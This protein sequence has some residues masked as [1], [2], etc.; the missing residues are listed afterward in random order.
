MSSAERV[1]LTA[2]SC[3]E[4]DNWIAKYPAEQRQSAVMAALRIA[5]E[6]NGGWLH[7]DL[8]QAVAD[9]LD[10]AVI[11]V[12]EVATFYSMYELEPVGRHK[13]SICTN[14]SCLL[15]GSEEVVAH[16]E[17]SLG[18]KLGESTADGRFTLKEVEC[19][20]ACVNAPMAQ[21]GRDYYEK[22]T[23]ET[24]DALL[25]QLRRDAS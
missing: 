15:C 7:Q 25:D 5:Q 17:K 4:I 20:G 16:F 11:A 3:R 9:Y 21:V 22:L 10:M 23:P 14:I 24:I 2:A 8:L 19:L 13:I 12:Y 1:T 18:I 6:Q